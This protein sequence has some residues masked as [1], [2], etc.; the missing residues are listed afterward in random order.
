MTTSYPNSEYA[1]EGYR[2]DP[3]LTAMMVEDM[4]FDPILACKVIL[5]IDLPPHEELR[6]LG[7][8]GTHFTMD[9][10]GFSTGKSFTHALII[11]LRSILIPGRISG[12]LSGTF[13]QGKLIFQ[14]LER[15]Y[16]KSKIFR[17]CVKHQMG[18]PRFVHGSELFQAMFRGGSEVRVLPP[19]ITQD[20]LRLRSER[21]NDG[22]IDEWVTFG[23]FHALTSTIFGRATAANHFTDCPVRQNH[24]HLSSTPG[25]THEPAY[26]LVK[27][28]DR[29]IQVGNQ[30]YWRFTCNYRHVPDT[31]RWHGLV[32]RK[33]IFSMQTMNPPGVVA[34]EIDGIWQ[35]DSQSYYSSLF[36]EEARVAAIHP[37]LKR[38]H[39]KDVYIGAFDTARGKNATKRAEGDDFAFTVWRIPQGTGTPY[40][41]HQVRK[42]N[43]TAVGMAGIVQELHQLFQF[44]WIVYDVMGGG[45]FVADK[46]TEP[47]QLIRGETRAVYPL[48]E[49]GSTSGVMGDPILIPFRR[50]AFQ[51]K[52]M[53]GTM[54]SDSV[55]INRMHQAMRH[56][57]ENHVIGLPPRWNGWGDEESRSNLD[58]MRTYLSKNIGLTDL[59]RSKAELDLAVRQLVVVDVE[60]DE[61]N[62][63][64]IDSHGMYRFT[65]H[66]KKDAAYSLCYGYLGVIIYHHLEKRGIFSGTGRQSGF[67][68]YVGGV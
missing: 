11:S 66:F 37:L 35:A 68:M 31:P 50:S 14:Y 23:N 15:W 12:V 5:D 65:S 19:S 40:P 27:R 38:Y 42:N 45:M 67:A 2:Y 9:D 30:D 48:V 39:E 52:Q 21:W 29:N 33:T 63:P 13:R 60:R 3:R 1:K 18:K 59:E 7:M 44:A 26:A 56:G 43:V 54:S 57:I 49:F 8:W 53:W 6:V 61:N 22:Y 25:Y 55:M 41:C 58:A 20:S 62:N 10:S 36:V 28:I 32:D 46:L 47:E 34:S 16:A 64:K 51:V 24:L 4:L 17:S